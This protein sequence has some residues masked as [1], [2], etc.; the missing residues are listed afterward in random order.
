MCYA[1]SRA[2]RQH[3]TNSACAGCLLVECLAAAAVGPGDDLQGVPVRIVPVHAPAPVVRVD[4]VRPAMA[5]VG[6]VAQAALLDAAE[7]LVEL[8]FADE[9]GVVRRNRLAVIVGEVQAHAIGRLQLEERSVA[10]GGWQAE[11]LGEEARRFFLVADP[12]DV[13]I[14]LNGHGYSSMDRCKRG[15]GRSR[16]S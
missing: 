13:V 6:P 4:R 16:P 3:A 8:S 2:P 11:D 1:G 9:E 5:R 7:D 12:D 10:S 15:G 14:E